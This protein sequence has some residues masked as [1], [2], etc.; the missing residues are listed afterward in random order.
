MNKLIT[1]STA[2]T[3]LG[4]PYCFVKYKNINLQQIIKITIISN[5]TGDYLKIYVTILFRNN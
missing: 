4:L 5:N 2:I 1:T 3:Y